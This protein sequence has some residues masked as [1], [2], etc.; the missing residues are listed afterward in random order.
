MKKVHK[1]VQK[2]SK[3]AFYVA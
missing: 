3:H 1:K 2:Y